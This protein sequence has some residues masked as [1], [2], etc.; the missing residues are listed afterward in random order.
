MEKAATAA[1]GKVIQRNKIR[2]LFKSAALSYSLA[3]NENSSEECG[4]GP[5]FFMW[6]VAGEKLG[7]SICCFRPESRVCLQGLHSVNSRPP[8]GGSKP[9]RENETLRR[10]V[11]S[12]REIT[13]LRY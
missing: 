8:A 2:F 9:D 3:D 11:T 13:L 5:S 6:Q 10:R 12:N 7:F 1:Q 4:G